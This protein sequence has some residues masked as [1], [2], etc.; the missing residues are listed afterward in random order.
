MS[1]LSQQ[2]GPETKEADSIAVQLAD[3][4]C[5]LLLPLDPS[6]TSNHPVVQ[7]YYACGKSVDPEQC[8]DQ[9]VLLCNGKSDNDKWRF[10]L[11]GARFL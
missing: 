8:K 5:K 6:L 7:E 10:A 11:Q 3:I 4:E 9:L 1:A 2:F